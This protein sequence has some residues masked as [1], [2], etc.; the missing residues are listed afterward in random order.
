MF[1]KNRWPPMSKRNPW[2]RIVW[3]RPPTCVSCSKTIVGTPRRVRSY[4]A[5]SPAGPAPI[6]TTGA[7]ADDDMGARIEGRPWRPHY[8]RPS[9]ERQIGARADRGG[10]APVG[11]VPAR[12]DRSAHGAHGARRVERADRRA[13]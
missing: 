1:V 8:S 11:R 7:L 5:V 10:S 9:D 2:W 4:A 13:G 12:A 3:A 6:T